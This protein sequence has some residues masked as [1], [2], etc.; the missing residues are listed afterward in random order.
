[1]GLENKIK[2]DSKIDFVGPYKPTTFKNRGEVRGVKP[3]MYAK[4]D[5][6]IPAKPK[7]EKEQAPSAKPTNGTRFLRIE[8]PGDNKILTLNEVEIFSGGKNV[9]RQGKAKQS[10]VGSG[11]V[12]ERGIDGNKNPDWGGAG[13]THTDGFGT[14]NPWWEV[15]LGKE[16]TVDTVQVWNRQGFEKRLDGFTIQLMDANRKQIYKSGKTKGAQRIKFTLKSRTYY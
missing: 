13:Q 10:S 5:S 3:S 11:G 12:P 7:A 4:L 14:T 1:M 8:I 16:F 15:D 9:A 2:P 6:P